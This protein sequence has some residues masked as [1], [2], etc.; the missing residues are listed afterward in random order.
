MTYPPNDP[1]T[2]KRMCGYLHEMKKIPITGMQLGRIETVFKPKETQCHYC[3]SPLGESSRITSKA[4]ILTMHTLYENVETFFKCCSSC[5]MCYRY[6]KYAGGIHNFNDNFLIAINVCTFLCESLQQH[7][8][9]GSVV[10]VLESH[11]ETPLDK[12]TILNAY[13]HFESLSS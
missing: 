12:Q 7:L 8:P 4:R 11:V 2:I 13:L 5:G 10:K 9:I 3:S 1:T 6:Q